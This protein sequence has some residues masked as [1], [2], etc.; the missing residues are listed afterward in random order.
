MDTQSAVLTLWYVTA[1]DP[2]EV[3]RGEPK[4]DRGFGRKFLA[5]LNPS[6]PVTPIGQF[7]LNRS[8]EPGASEFYVGGYPGV[9]VVQTIIHDDQLILSQLSRTLREAVPATEIYAFASNPESGYAGFAHWTGSR[10]RRSLCGTRFNLYEDHGLPETFEAPFWAGEMDEPAGG[11]SL[12]F[13]PLTITEAAQEFWLGIEVG[14]DGP[15]VDVVGYATDGRPEPKVDTPPP[16]RS[17]AEV[18]TTS[19]A[20][21]G[22]NDYDDYE[23]HDLEPESTGEEIIRTA[24]HLGGLVRRYAVSTSRSLWERWR[25]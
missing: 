18:A 3:L 13:E 1:A 5:Q 19:V 22:L 12:P 20:K 14:E 16:R 10:L 21:L 9:T 23:E 15:D 6:L 7:P 8:A 2:A 4:A 11:I 17:V 25:S 24:K